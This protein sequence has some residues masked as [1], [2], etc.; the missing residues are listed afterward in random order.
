MPS[1]RQDGLERLALGSQGELRIGRG[2]PVV[3]PE[4]P[5][6]GQDLGNRRLFDSV[7]A[8]IVLDLE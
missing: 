2:P 5:P 8:Q 3:L 4:A 1:L 6:Q 7:G